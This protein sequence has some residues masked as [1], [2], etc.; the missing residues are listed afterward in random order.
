[1]TG[2]AVQLV[3]QGGSALVYV[4]DEANRD[5]VIKRVKKAFAGVEG[6]GEGRRAG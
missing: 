5:D 2:G 3:I 1:M 4:A 6:V